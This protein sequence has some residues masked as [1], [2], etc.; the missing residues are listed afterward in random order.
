MKEKLLEMVVWAEKEEKGLAIHIEAKG[1]PP[2]SFA[3]TKQDEYDVLFGALK[4]L[5]K[6][7]EQV[8]GAV[9][10]ERDAW[11]IDR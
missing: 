9:T 11:S 8:S 10:T 4:A 6:R 7:F 5:V 1:V 2:R 3:I